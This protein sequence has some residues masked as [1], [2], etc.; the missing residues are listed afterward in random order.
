MSKQLAAYELDQINKANASGRQPVVFVHGL[1]LLPNS[2]DRWA[3]RF[4][5]E[6]YYAIQPGWPDDPQTVEEAAADPEKFA[7]KSIGQVAEHYERVIHALD[8]KPAI[9]GH[10][11]GGLLAEILAGRGLAA[12]TVAISPAAYRGVLPLPV[13]S[14]KSA[15][16]VLKNPQNKHRAVAL[17]LEQFQFAFANAVP[18]D[19]AR[20]LYGRFAVPGAGEPLFQSAAANVNPWTED[21]VESNP[22]RGPM[23][24]IAGELDHTVPPAVVNASYEIEKRFDGVT[25]YLAIPGRGHSLTID[26]GWSDVA[27]FALAFVRRYAPA[28]TA[29]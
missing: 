16:P 6:G 15:W 10:S 3:E 13:S 20:D 29:V 28:A 2:W 8:K 24:L 23:L 7:N 14:L 22:D 9:V 11:F 21:K 5:A 25:D 19:E 12:V 4:D 17:T 18:D 27:D 26:H 1:W